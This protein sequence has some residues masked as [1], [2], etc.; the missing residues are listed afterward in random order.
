MKENKETIYKQANFERYT[1]L[2]MV[3]AYLESEWSDFLFGAEN[4]KSER[5]NNDPMTAIVQPNFYKRIAELAY[6]AARGAK[7]SPKRYCDVGGATGRL[8]S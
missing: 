7:I 6:S 5:D 8:L 3:A 4:D 2:S 1:N